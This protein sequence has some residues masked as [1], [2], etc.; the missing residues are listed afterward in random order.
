EGAI[1]RSGQDVQ[2]EPLK[3]ARYQVMVEKMQQVAFVQAGGNP[4]EHRPERRKSLPVRARNQHRHVWWSVGIVQDSKQGVGGSEGA[5]T[6][7]MREKR[8]GCFR[9]EKHRLE[10]VPLFPKHGDERVR[11]EACPRGSLSRR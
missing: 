11:N 1:H 3:I 2:E 10:M 9:K 8:G 6:V 7:Q 5:R 4:L